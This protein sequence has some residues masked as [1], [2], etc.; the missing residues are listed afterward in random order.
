MPFS[1]FNR[2]AVL[3]VGRVSNECSVP[4]FSIVCGFAVT[5]GFMCGVTKRSFRPFLMGSIERYDKDRRFHII[6]GLLT[7]AIF[8]FFP[9]LVRSSDAVFTS[10]NRARVRFVSVLI[11]R[12]RRVTSV[13]FLF[14]LFSLG[15]NVRDFCGVLSGRESIPIKCILY[16]M[17]PVAPREFKCYLMAIKLNRYSGSYAT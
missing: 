17:L 13:N 4:Y 12:I 14:R 5:Y 15:G 11:P 3:F 2:R 6:K 7:S 10:E 16:F 9:T 8:E 1:I